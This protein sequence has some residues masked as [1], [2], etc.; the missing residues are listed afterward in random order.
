MLT[1]PF[2]FIFSQVF[3]IFSILFF[4]SVSCLAY[5]GALYCAFLLC[6]NT[7]LFHCSGLSTATSQA[8]LS[9][10]MSQGCPLGLVKP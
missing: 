1:K 4:V 2:K 3:V 5:S 6:F 8:H 10:P 9:E 7:E